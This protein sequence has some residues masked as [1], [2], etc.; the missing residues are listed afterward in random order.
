[1]VQIGISESFG[2]A[3]WVAMLL[4]DRGY[5]VSVSKD[6]GNGKMEESLIAFTGINNALAAN[7]VIRYIES[8][9]NKDLEIE[10]VV[11]EAE[12]AAAALLRELR[13]AA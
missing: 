12:D 8:N 1:M 11:F 7:E 9:L 2:V 10:L 3:G 5:K 13:L 4:L 6:P